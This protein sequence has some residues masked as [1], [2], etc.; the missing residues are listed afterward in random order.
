MPP[1]K[2]ETDGIGHEGERP[3]G[4]HGGRQGRHPGTKVETSLQQDTNAEGSHDQALGKGGAGAPR[5]ASVENE[6]AKPVDKRVAQHVERVSKEGSGTGQ[7]AGPELDKEH[8]GIDRKHDDQDMPLTETDCGKF[9]RLGFA[10]LVHRALAPHGAGQL[11]IEQP[12]VYLDS[13][14]V[15]LEGEWCEEDYRDLMVRQPGEVPAD[16]LA[17]LE[18]PV[19]LATDHGDA[20]GY[21]GA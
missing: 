5:Q 3:D 1:E 11:V 8:G 10:T 18:T 16:F 4:H 15:R 20:S 19:A 6:Q 21:L 7:E 2:G 9:C 17:R 14:E 12:A 13:R